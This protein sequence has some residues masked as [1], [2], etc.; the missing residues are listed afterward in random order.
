MTYTTPGSS[1]EFL[2]YPTNKVVGVFADWTQARAALDALA[3]DGVAAEQVGVLHGPEG[4]A[5]LDATGERHGILAQISRFF[6]RFAD[7]DDKHTQRHEQELAAGHVLV[8]VYVGDDESARARTRDLLKQH[9]G[10]FINFYG[11]WYVENLA[12]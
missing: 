2:N 12:P 9:G 5:R 10:Y 11:K 7:M 1:G 6:Q 3:A 8:E 4:A